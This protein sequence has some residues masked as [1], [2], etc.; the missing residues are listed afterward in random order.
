M[1]ELLGS[2]LLAILLPQAF[3]QT[4]INFNSAGDLATYFNTIS[5]TVSESANGGISDSR[6]VIGDSNLVFI[7]KNGLSS[8]VGSTLNVSTSFKVTAPGV[9]NDGSNILQVQVGFAMS[10]TSMS[11]G[12]DST[13]SSYYTAA[14]PDLQLRSPNFT[15]ALNG[16]GPSAVTVTANSWYRLDLAITKNPTAGSWTYNVNLYDIGSSGTSTATYIAGNAV[17]QTTGTTNALNFY[18]ASTLYP[19]ITFYSN[20]TAGTPTFDNVIY[21]ATAVPEP[22]TYTLVLGLA[23]CAVTGW[24]RYRR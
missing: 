6:S 19:A 22:S 16:T 4:T 21:S 15:A 7:S 5:G 12:T 8:N 2:A 24:R 14:T 17:T 10:S 1:R 3:S 11:P 23:A 13:L 18:N 9:D 20:G